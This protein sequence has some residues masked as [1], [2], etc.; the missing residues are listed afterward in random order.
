MTPEPLQPAVEEPKGMG[1]VSRL[2]GVFFEP[3]K[4]FEDVAQRPTWVVPMVVL[5]LCGLAFSYM[6][7][8][9]VGW[10]R[11]VDQQM[12]SALEKAS[13][14]QRAAMEQR[15]PMQKQ[16]AP[17]AAYGFSLI[18]PI[19]MGLIVAGVLTGIAGGI[20][21][22]GVRFKQV[23]AIFFYSGMVGVIYL[24]LTILMMFLK[25]PDDFNIRNPLAFNVGAFLDPQTTSKFVYSIATAFDVFT[26]WRIALIAIGLKAAAGKRL[27]MGGAFATVIVPWLVV[28][29]CGAGLAGIFG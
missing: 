18:G 10:S 21:G 14:E 19:L 28:A 1:E 22:A 12:Q 6:L 20:L 17:V 8:S 13:P 4:V 3:G 2:T 9:R 16:F 26:F 27:S 15:I 25:A 7:G 23:L 5:M 29:F 24:L 11:V